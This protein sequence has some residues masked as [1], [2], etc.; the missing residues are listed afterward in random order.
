[1]QCPA[2]RNACGIVDHCEARTSKRAGVPWE[3]RF[4]LARPRRT[5]RF[6]RRHL[7]RASAPVRQADR[8]FETA[9]DRER[10]EDA[11]RVDAR[12][13]VRSV[14]GAAILGIALHLQ[15]NGV[16]C[17]HDCAAYRPAD[18]LPRRRP[19]TFPGA[20]KRGRIVRL[21]RRPDPLCGQRTR[22]AGRADSRL[23]RLLRPALGGT[24]RVGRA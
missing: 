15:N 13:T 2:A 4:S 24:R 12:C 6:G 23:H 3:W 9:W 14:R 7:G 21:E 17:P 1:V 22:C 18:H 20:A 10:L 11:P 19:C 5:T 16:D 8:H